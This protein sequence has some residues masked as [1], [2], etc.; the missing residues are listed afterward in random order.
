MDQIDKNILAT[1]Q[2][3]GRLPIVDLAEQ[4]HLSKSACLQRL[5]KLEKAGYILGYHAELNPKLLSQGYLVYVL[6]KLENTSETTLAAFN[7]AVA[8]IVQIQTCHMMTGG[9]DYLLKIRCK[10][11]QA[12]RHLLG[13]VITHLPAVYQTSTFPVMEEI[14]DHNFLDFSEISKQAGF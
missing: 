9:Y 12:Y 8:D 14:K 11:S 4:V 2:Q 1:L 3:N 6:V 13:H 10:D 7:M 5:R